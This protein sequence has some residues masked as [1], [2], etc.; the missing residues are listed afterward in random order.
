MKFLVDELVQDYDGTPYRESENIGGKLVKKEK[1][2]AYREV[3][4]WC[5]QAYIQ[6]E[7]KEDKNKIYPVGL[8]AGGGSKEVELD[9]N[10]IALVLKRTEKL[11]NALVLGRCEEFFDNPLPKKADG[12]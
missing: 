8:K 2:L 7:T 3:L 11:Y 1:P 6:D 5:A 10:Q 12:K 9:N 4:V